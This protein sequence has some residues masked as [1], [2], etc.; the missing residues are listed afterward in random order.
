MATKSW[1]EVNKFRLFC[2][3]GL[4]MAVQLNDAM[5]DAAVRTYEVFTIL[6]QSAIAT[7]AYLQCP[8]IQ[9]TKEERE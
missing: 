3:I 5:S 2:F 9:R 1:K 6:I 7:F 4:T 8:T